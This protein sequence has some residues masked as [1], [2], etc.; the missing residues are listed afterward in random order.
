MT[1]IVFL[2]IPVVLF[3][4]LQHVIFINNLFTQ[5][6]CCIPQPENILVDLSSPGSTPLI[7]LIDFGDARHIYDNTYVHRLMGS[8]EFA[9]PELVM[10]QPASL[11]SDIW[12]V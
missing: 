12:S 6:D 3:T 2:C 5:S 7:K 8:A 9:A 10:G 4:V 1:L 11:L